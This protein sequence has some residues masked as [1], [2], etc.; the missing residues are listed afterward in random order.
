MGKFTIE[1]DTKV[2]EVNDK[3][4]KHDFCF[5]LEGSTFKKAYFPHFFLTI[6]A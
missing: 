4:V 2:A 6:V 5:T 3:K 1:S